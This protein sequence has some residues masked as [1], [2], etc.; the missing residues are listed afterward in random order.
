MWKFIKDWD[1]KVEIMWATVA[2]MET[3]V[4]LVLM[5]VAMTFNI[6]LF[7]AMCSGTFFGSL[8]FGHFANSS[9]VKHSCH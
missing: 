1:W 3:L 8:L 9:H 6:G 2:F 5:L 7:L 4:G